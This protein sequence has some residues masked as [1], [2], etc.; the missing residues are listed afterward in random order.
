MTMDRRTVL[1]ASTAMGTLA[2][3]GGLP[4]PALSQTAA[5]RTLRFVPQANLANFDPVWGTQLV[6]RNAAAMVW[7]TLYGVD[8]RLEP[9][10]QMVEAEEQTDG[11]KTW[12]FRL[13]EG[14][15]FHDGE[16]VRARDVVASPDRW[17]VRDSSMGQMIRGFQDELAAVDDRTFRWRLKQPYPRLKIAL[18]NNNVPMAFVMP[19]RLARTDPFQ[20]ITE[21]IGSG[22]M[23]FARDEWVPGARAV[24]T[25]FDGYAPRAEPASWL[26]GGKR[27]LVDRVEWVVIPDPAT[28]SAALQNGE[29]DWWETPLT[30]LV[31]TLRRN[32]NITVDIADPLGNVGGFIF[33]HLHPPFNDVRA[34]RAIAMAL[35]QR[36]YMQAVVGGDT[37]L[38][39]I[40]PGF[41]TPNTPLYTEAGG[42]VLK[43]PR[44]IAGARRLL[45][46]AG[47]DGR[48][49]TVLVAQD[50]AAGRAGPR[51]DE[52]DGRGDPRP[53]AVARHERGLRRHRLGHRRR[54]PR[55]QELAGARRL[56]RLPQ[57]VPRGARD[58]PGLLPYAARQWR[59]RLVRLAHQPRG[60]GGARQVVRGAGFRGREGGG[61]RDER[62]GA[63]A[64]HLPPDQVL[65]DLPGVAEQRDRCDRRA[66]SLL[67]GCRKGLTLV[68]NS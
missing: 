58:Q 29:V 17:T 9:R 8:D 10:R 38:W 35:D 63:L 40:L 49:V 54:S 21:C 56:E 68:L 23:R 55:G 67:L 16:P 33:N 46:E 60:G 25:R 64:R 66:P 34:R 47:Y 43:G 26:A 41:F 44:D 28:A 65:Q 37:S 59:A 53:A 62:R 18:G 61:G 32:R 39:Q 52:G 12:T 50:L 19:E 48:P 6:V 7:D 27:M 51:A 13:R 2:A 1:R 5:S 4:A 15:R 11:G 31:P 24:F 57:L 36:D 20:Q 30:D 3:T 14:L 22:P 42:E 45:A